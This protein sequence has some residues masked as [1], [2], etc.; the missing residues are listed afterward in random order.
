MKELVHYQRK[1]NDYG[2]I[3]LD[4]QEKHNAISKRMAEDFKRALYTARED[5]VK[6]LVITGAGNKMFCAGGDLIDFH[7]DLS[8]ES[9]YELL[10]YI[11]EIL[12]AIVTFPVPTVCLLNGNALGGGCEI[13]TACDFRIA[14]ASTTFGFI[15][16]KLGIIPGWG[17]GALLYEKVHSSFAYQWL[18]EA[19]TFS[20]EYLQ[21]QGWLHQ[22]IPEERWKNQEALLHM[23]ITK[24]YNQMKALKEQYMEELNLPRLSEKMNKEVQNCANL[25]DSEEHIH[26]VQ[27]FLK[28]K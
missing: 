6:L 23:Y 15:Q 9:S 17:G 26:A 19:E 10:N 11:K 7:A 13:A 22:L 1:N 14:K 21:R 3:M 18:M 12:Y 2:V 27:Q 20:A 5:H 16:S 28:Q 24:S 8:P 4:R 25:W